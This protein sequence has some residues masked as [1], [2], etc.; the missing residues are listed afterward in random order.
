MGAG[1]SEEPG[2]SARRLSSNGA[3][4]D[5]SRATVRVDAPSGT[6][7]VVFGGRSAEG[8]VILSKEHLGSGGAFTIS[9]NDT[10]V[11]GIGVDGGLSLHGNVSVADGCL[12][13]PTS[14]LESQLEGRF[15][16]L[17]TSVSSGQ[18]SWWSSSPRAPVTY[19]DL[20][21]VSS[22]LKGFVGGFATGSHACM[23]RWSSILGN[24]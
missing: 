18:A 16:S 11:I 15:T 22:G 21:S 13:Q 23:P 24:V 7:E 3:S 9:R 5:G 4:A 8:N 6:S 2:A 20:T 1:R 10:R 17:E 19:L 12:V 14:C